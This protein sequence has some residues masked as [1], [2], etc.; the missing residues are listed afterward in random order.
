MSQVDDEIERAH[1]RRRVDEAVGPGVEVVAER[2]DPHAGR[3]IGELLDAVADL[4]RDQPH[5]GNRG[6]RREGGER[7]RARHVGLGIRIALPDD[8]DL[9]ALG[10]DARRPFPRALRLGG[11]IG[12]RSRH[13]VEP[14]GESARQAADGDLGVE[15]FAR[16]P[17][18]DE[19]DPGERRQQ[20]VQARR[21]QESRLG[22]GGGHQRQVAAELDSVAEAVVVH[23]Q[24]ALAG[25][26]EAA[27]SG[28]TRAERLGERLALDPT[29]FVALPTVLEVAERQ[30]EAAL[31]G[32]RLDVAE[33]NRL[34]EC[35]ERFVDAAKRA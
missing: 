30:F 28:K 25:P 17:F 33:P 32:D 11:K 8:A 27:P 12:N 35:V 2:L 10:A 29:R 1:R 23:H 21:A 31:A 26:A 9:E 20:A 16:R 19:A 6:E 18:A 24:H 5:A 3:Q 15:A 22:A 34:L 7:H 4:Q 14:G 13:V